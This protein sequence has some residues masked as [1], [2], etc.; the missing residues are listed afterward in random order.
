MPDLGKSNATYAKPLDVPGNLFVADGVWSG[1]RGPPTM[2]RQIKSAGQAR[3]HCP[4]L[5]L[6]NITV[7]CD[8]RKALMQFVVSIILVKV[9]APEMG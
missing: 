8:W 5:V 1:V 4:A 3:G 9:A 6:L 2:W 7:K